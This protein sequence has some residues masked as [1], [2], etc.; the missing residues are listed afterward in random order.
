MVSSII[1]AH[2]DVGD[3]SGMTIRPL[4]CYART[5]QVYDSDGRGEGGY[6][7]AEIRGATFSE[8]RSAASSISISINNIKCYRQPVLREATY[9]VGM[10]GTF[11]G[12]VLFKGGKV[13]FR[14]FV[15]HRKIPGVQKR[16]VPCQY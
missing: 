4:P 2:L 16:G 15:R 11:V 3:A 7:L 14:A 8:L 6:V 5:N 10:D 1:V 12:V 9:E 13:P